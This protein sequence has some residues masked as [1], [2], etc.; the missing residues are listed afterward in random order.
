MTWRKIMVRTLVVTAFLTASTFASAHENKMSDKLIMELGLD[1]ARASQVQEIMQEAKSTAVE[2]RK[3]HFAQMKEHREQTRAQL[4]EI[5]SEEEMAK[6]EEL[7]SSKMKSKR[8]H[9]K[10]MRGERFNHDE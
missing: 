5:L 9:E 3:S 8:F 6:L 2:I 1:E 7:R 4:S 10:H